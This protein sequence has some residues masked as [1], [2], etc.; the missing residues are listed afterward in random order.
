MDGGPNW[1]TEGAVKT[2]G[3]PGYSKFSEGPE[4]NFRLG[5]IP[6]QRSFFFLTTLGGEGNSLI[7]G[8]SWVGKSPGFH[9]GWGS[10]WLTF[11]GLAIVLKISLSGWFQTFSVHLGPQPF[12]F[13]VLWAFPGS[14]KS[15]NSVRFMN[16]T[17]TGP[18]PRKIKIPPVVRSGREAF[19]FPQI[20]SGGFLVGGLRWRP[21]RGWRLRGSPFSILPPRQASFTG[22]VRKSQGLGR[23]TFRFQGIA[24][25]NRRNSGREKV[26]K[27]SKKNYD[28]SPVVIFRFS[29]SFR[30]S[31]FG[32]FCRVWLGQSRPPFYSKNRRKYRTDGHLCFGGPG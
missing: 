29:L 25:R 1:N 21:L 15:R 13:G 5:N 11:G 12:R 10:C 24:R 20:G 4:A 27:V 26:D 19:C 17:E 16:I 30:G 7:G 6:Q 31:T 9:G 23:V 3:W 8:S 32:I 28:P 18:N 22:L 2:G 14:L